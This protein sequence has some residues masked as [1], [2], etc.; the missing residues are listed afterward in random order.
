MARAPERRK[1]V[2]VGLAVLDHLLLW[3]D[4]AEPV[5]GNR[6]IGRSSG[7]SKAKAGGGDC[8]SSASRV[9]SPATA[10]TRKP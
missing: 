8:Q 5:A 1:V 10:T 3:R 4:A 6:I 2:G 9:E 7:F